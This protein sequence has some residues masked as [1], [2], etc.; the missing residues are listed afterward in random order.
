VI[1]RFKA[2]SSELGRD[3]PQDRQRR[4]LVPG[5]GSIGQ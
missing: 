5:E 2:A 1:G 3:V 4:S